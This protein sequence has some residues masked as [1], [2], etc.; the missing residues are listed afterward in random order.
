MPICILI[1]LLLLIPTAL[2]DDVTLFVDSLSRYAALPCGLD[3]NSLCPD[4]ESALLSIALLTTD[5]QDTVH[6]IFLP[7]NHT[8]CY[9]QYQTIVS[10]T[11]FGA[12]TLN[13]SALHSHTAILQCQP[14]MVYATALMFILDEPGIR[15]F[16]QYDGTH[17]LIPKPSEN[18]YNTEW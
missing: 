1:S 16:P 6:I 3:F 17:S 13:F 5:P 11:P 8:V 14:S 15:C 9:L 4:A 12:T 7:G 2:G 10:P 18:C